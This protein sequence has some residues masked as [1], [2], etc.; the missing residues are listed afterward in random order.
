VGESW[1]A[2]WDA[3]DAAD[4]EWQ[5]WARR[6]HRV[7]RPAA[8]RAHGPRAHEARHLA[9]TTAGR[10]L[11]ASVAA[12]AAA[13]IFGLVALWSPSAH[14]HAPTQALGGPTLG[15]TVTAVRTVA[16]PGPTPQACR[17]IAIDVG[18]RRARISLGPLTVSPSVSVGQ[19]VRVARN[20]LPPGVQPAPGFETYSFVGVDRHGS[21]LIMALALAGFALL[22]LRWRGVLAVVGVGLSLLLLTWFM[23]PAIL[24]G[25]PA[26]LVALVGS[27]A[28]MF[29][30]L[31]L[32]NGVGAQSLAGALGIA[33]TLGLTSALAAAFTGIA[34]L[35]GRSSELTL[36]LSQQDGGLSL[37]GVILAGMVIGALGVLADTAVTQA[38]AVMALRRANPA[39]GPTSLYRGALAVGRDHLSATIHTLVLAYAGAALPLLLAMRSAGVGLT[40]ALNAQ[41][42]A[43]PVLATIV[44]CIGLIAAVPLTTGLATL[45]VSRLPLEVV[46]EGHPHHGH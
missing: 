46:P 28:V 24:A 16:C 31:V 17:Q 40:D 14:R 5:A 32:T 7:E 25:R 9:G 27:M 21:L 30:T 3:D 29:V 8:R 44:G 39:L 19:A 36:F 12:L 6:Q 34:H 13:T 10:V 2:A 45:L 43:E 20:H 38:S 22:V 35:D 1:E 42:V 23:V 11:I 18:G 26:V 33:A 37:S 15:A 41:D 4:L